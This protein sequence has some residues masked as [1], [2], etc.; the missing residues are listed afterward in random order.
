MI[1]DELLDNISVLIMVPDKVYGLISAHVKL[2]AM[3]ILQTII[4]ETTL[5]V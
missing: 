4:H 3:S 2:S 5:P 1:V